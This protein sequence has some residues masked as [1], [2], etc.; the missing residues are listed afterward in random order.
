MISGA[1]YHLTN[2]KEK[3][4]QLYYRPF[5]RAHNRIDLPCGH[6]ASHFGFGWSGQTKIQNSQLTIFINSNVGRFQI[7]FTI[8]YLLEKRK[9]KTADL[10]LRIYP[11]YNTGT[12]NI[13]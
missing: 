1:R 10:C 11:M 8:K 4:Q 3:T 5:K 9:I 7:L 13:F 2:K 12:V 6:I